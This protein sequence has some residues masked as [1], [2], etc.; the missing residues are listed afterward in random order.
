M[1]RRR[2]ST[3]AAA[4]GRGPLNGKGRAVADAIVGMENAL[5]KFVVL[6]AFRGVHGRTPVRILIHLVGNVG[7]LAVATPALI[8]IRSHYPAARIALLT[9]T[10]STSLP[11]AAEL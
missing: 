7:D 9:S 2:A 8:A 4:H 1:R 11:G 10:G 6:A 5:L 3:D